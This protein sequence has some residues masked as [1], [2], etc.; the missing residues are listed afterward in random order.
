MHNIYLKYKVETGYYSKKKLKQTLIEN[1]WAGLTSSGATMCTI[2]LFKDESNIIV[3][4]DDS[5]HPVKQLEILR[6]KD[7]LSN[8][9]QS[10]LILCYNRLF[11]SDQQIRQ[12]DSNLKKQ[13]SDMTMRE[14]RKDDK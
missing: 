7:K 9:E 14:P 3:F 10:Q 11:H 13:F 1:E 4:H 5:T 6:K 8:S 2:G 12:W